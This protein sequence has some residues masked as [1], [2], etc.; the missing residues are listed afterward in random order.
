MIPILKHHPTILIE[1]G[2]IDKVLSFLPGYKIKQSV[3]NDFLLW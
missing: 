2:E 3:N 1:T